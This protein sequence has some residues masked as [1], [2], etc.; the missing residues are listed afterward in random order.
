MIRGNALSFLLLVFAEHCIST[1]VCA[2]A[3]F[4]IHG[5]STLCNVRY[6]KTN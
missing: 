2:Y 5:R 3:F 1:Y 6:S 4:N